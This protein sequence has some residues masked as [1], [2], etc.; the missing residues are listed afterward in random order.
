MSSSVFFKF[1]SSKEPTIIK[2]DGT[3]ISV[4]ELK[5]EII[6]VSGLGDGTNFDL[7][8]Y[9]EETG[10]GMSGNPCGILHS[11]SVAN[12]LQEYDDDTTI[13][14]RATSVVAR[15]LPAS[16]PGHGRAAR[17]ISGKKP[18]QARN[19]TEASHKSGVTAS[20]MGSTGIAT[21]LNEAQTEEE[22]IAAMFR[23]GG[24]QWEQQQQE[25]AR[26]VMQAGIYK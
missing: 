22:R 14:P 18:I 2:F 5:Q 4:F 21:G 20:K 8:I 7:S 23:A 3:G 25:M 19:R 24:E 10:E 1:K 13:V 16:K 26:S 12:K 15:R 6:N 11:F 9:N 17:Y